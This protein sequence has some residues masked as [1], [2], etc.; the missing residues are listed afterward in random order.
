MGNC[1]RLTSKIIKKCDYFGTFV[2]FRIND[3]I[4][5][6][7]IV[8]GLTSIIFFILAFAYTIYVA[9]PFIK[10]EN[11]DFIFSNKVVENQPFINLT[12]IKFNMA[13][14]IQYQDDAS[15]AIKDYEKY[16][17]YSMILKEWIG[18]DTIIEYPFGLKKCTK[19]DFFYLVNDSFDRN[20]VDG[21][22]CPILNESANYTLDGL[23]TDYYYKFFELEIKLTENGMENLNRI[24]ELM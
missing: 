24:K 17:N 21:L 11:I 5:Y 12:Q 9:Y 6:K 14:G 23:Y 22:L 1:C 18:D 4:E 19:S 15:S 7:S 20:N 8:G 2:T 10:R 3:E 16:F 13:F